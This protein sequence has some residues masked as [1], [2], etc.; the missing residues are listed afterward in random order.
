MR[1]FGMSLIPENIA[2]INVVEDIEVDT[3]ATEEYLACMDYYISLIKSKAS[4]YPEH[5]DEMDVYQDVYLSLQASELRGEGYNPDRGFTV[6][7]FISGRIEGYLKNEKYRGKDS[8]VKSIAASGSVGEDDENGIAFL[9]NNHADDYD[10]E[11]EIIASDLEESLRFLVVEGNSVGV[12]L[13]H[14]IKNPKEFVGDGNGKIPQSAKQIMQMLKKKL[15]K[16]CLEE[17]WEVLSYEN[18]G[19]RTLAIEKIEREMEET[20]ALWGI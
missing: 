2:C 3:S 17:L 14:M 11:A 20:G 13:L 4:K 10:L 8:K 7:Q 5:I 18:K 6:R 15:S 12:N 9:Y 16:E 1:D 19:A